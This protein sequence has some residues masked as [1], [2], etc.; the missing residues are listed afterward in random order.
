M[1]SVTLN[2]KHVEV[3]VFRHLSG[4]FVSSVTVL[5]R[6]KVSV[7]QYDLKNVVLYVRVK[8]LLFGINLQLCC[9]CFMQ[10]DIHG[11]IWCSYNSLIV[12]EKL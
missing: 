6:S 8:C 9:C 3:L 1:S 10:K 2:T 12:R 7:I 5:V 11:I 4:A